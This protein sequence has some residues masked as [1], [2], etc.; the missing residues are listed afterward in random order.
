[1]NKLNS[2]DNSVIMIVKL[3]IRIIIDYQAQ[4]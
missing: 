1:M 2:G 3:S 4:Y